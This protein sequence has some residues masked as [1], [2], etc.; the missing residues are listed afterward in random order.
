MSY[1]Q[2]T[3]KKE[4]HGGGRSKGALLSPGLS[5]T[6]GGPVQSENAEPLAQDLRILRWQQ[7]SIKLIVGKFAV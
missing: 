7:Q 5:R 6:L 3:R 4:V 2:T 1:V